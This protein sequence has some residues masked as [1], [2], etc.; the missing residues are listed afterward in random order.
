MYVI[1]GKKIHNCK[2]KKDMNPESSKR[3]NPLPNAISG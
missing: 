1:P 2:L 3:K